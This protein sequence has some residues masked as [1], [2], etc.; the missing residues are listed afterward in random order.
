MKTGERFLT[1]QPELAAERGGAL[2]DRIS[3]VEQELGHRIWTIVMLFYRADTA[4]REQFESYE[5][6]VE[7]YSKLLGRAREEL[8]LNSRELASLL[9]LKNMERL[10]DGYIHDLKDLCHIVFRGQDRTD[11]LDRYVSDIFHEISILK[12]EHYNVITYAPLYE[13]DAAEVE[14]KHILDEAHALFP[15]KLAH[16]RYLFGRARQR[17]EEH[18]ASFSRIQLFIR[19]LYVHREDFVESAYEAGLDA[20]YRF[21][22]PLGPVEG[23]FH[24]GCS[25]F[26]SGFFKEAAE[27]F[28]QAQE[29]RDRLARDTAAVQPLVPES[30]E[31]VR[32]IARSIAGYERRLS[33]R[34]AIA[35]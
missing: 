21:M 12:E 2:K 20:F 25:F 23:Y 3:T 18:L 28:A 32:A 11:L 16:I 6:K 31:R 8:R 26:H 15:Q 27:A 24:V 19:S 22:Y 4:F 34:E 30:A 29:A 17:L 9:D 35:S 7:S 13:E 14:L 1:D 5:E 10:R 33:R